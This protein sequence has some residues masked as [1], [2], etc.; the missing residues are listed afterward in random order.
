MNRYFVFKKV[1]SVDAKKMADIILKSDLE[2]EQIVSE[3]LGDDNAAEDNPTAP[4]PKVRK[5]KKSKIILKN[6]DAD[7]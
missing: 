1:R 3:I 6:S 5:M 7:K 4:K 2:T